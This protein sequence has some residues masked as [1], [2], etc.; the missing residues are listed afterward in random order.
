MGYGF[1]FKRNYLFNISTPEENEMKMKIE[2]EQ[3]KL[4]EEMIGYT[5]ELTKLIIRNKINEYTYMITMMEE[6][7]DDL[8]HMSEDMIE[9]ILDNET[10]SFLL[11]R[12]SYNHIHNNKC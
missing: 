1:Y 2:Q 12:M 6:R 7:R 5:Q 10:I 11:N 4:L 9:Y 3:K 8:M